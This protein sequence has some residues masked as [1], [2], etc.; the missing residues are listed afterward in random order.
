[1]SDNAIIEITN[2]DQYLHF[3]GRFNKQQS[4]SFPPNAV[5]R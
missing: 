1:M 3:H 2:L 4:I 5:T